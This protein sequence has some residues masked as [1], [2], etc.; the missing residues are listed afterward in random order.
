MQFHQNRIG[1]GLNQNIKNLNLNDEVITA[2]KD[3]NFHIYPVKTIDE[4]SEILTGVP[5]GRKD[6]EGNFPLG[7]IN[8]LISKK[9]EK[10][11]DQAKKYN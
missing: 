11:A 10:F 9:L 1:N 2:V 5:A 8:Y 7:T 3:G 6:S 4:G